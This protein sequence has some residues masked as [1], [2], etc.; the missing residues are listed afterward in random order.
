MAPATGPRGGGGGIAHKSGPRGRGG[1]ITKRRSDA[2]RTD[3][4]GDVAMEPAARSGSGAQGAGGGTRGTR[5]TRGLSS[6]HVS[7]TRRIAQNLR[8]YAGEN[9]AVSKSQFH[10]TTLKIRGLASSKAA[11]NS[12]GGLRALL[13]FL[14]RKSSKEKRITIGKSIL[15][16]DYVW[17]SVNK[18]DASDVLHLNGYSYA[19][20]PLEITET[21]ERMPNKDEKIS[22][23]A[24]ETK[25]KLIAVVA[26]RYNAEQKLLDLSALG[27]DVILSSMGTFNSANLAE[28]AFKALV[29]IASLQYKTA[30]EKREALQAVSLA[31]NDIND[32]DQVFQL[33]YSLPDL[34]RLDLSDNNLATTSKIAKWQHRFRYLE[35]LHL[36]G[37]PIVTQENYLA[38]LLQWFPSLQNLN[39][40]QVRTPEQAAMSLKALDPTPLPQYPSNLRDGDN[41]VT[42]LFVQAFFPMFDTDRAR[43]AAEFYDEES[44]FSIAVIPNSGRPLPWKAYLKFSRNVQRLGGRSPGLVQR[45]FTGGNVIK[46]MW[47]VLPA[48]RHPSM[49]QPG[50][51]L[52]DCHTFPHLADPSGQGFA[53]GLIINVNGRFEESDA[54]TNMFGTRTFS[55][56]FVL[57]PS[58]PSN[59]PPVHPYRVLSDQLTLHDWKPEV[60]IVS[61]APAVAQPHVVVQAPPVVAPVPMAPVAGVLDDMTRNQLIQGLSNRTG[62]TA[63]YSELCLSGAANWNFD[64]A[65]ASFEEQKA[66]LPPIAFRAT[67]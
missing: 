26:R 18:N 29:H 20:A 36:T 31:R 57:G 3:R 59:P 62:M 37:N 10:K 15:D 28:K 17:I 21:S 27:A 12:D 1:G 51:W 42:A 54:S 35:E 40:Q 9:G 53:T 25:N 64:H 66:N 5:G 11:S 8:N 39:G 32:V 2:I 33:A 50:Q 49:D 56:T 16:G 44:W 30:D 55:R 52:I 38:D 22:R 63:E 60:A 13:E 24:E 46:D 23:D 61:Q 47:K 45:L 4:D 41:N 43:L 48:T 58:K 7:T 34:R 19:G 6:R 65:L 14:E 67:A